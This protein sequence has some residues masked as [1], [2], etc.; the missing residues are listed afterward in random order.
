MRAA[1]GTVAKGVW[2]ALGF[3]RGIGQA[4]G[5]VCAE[6]LCPYPPG[7]PAIAP[8]EVLS[9]EVLAQLQSV[10]ALG[11]SVNGAGDDT[12]STVEVIVEEQL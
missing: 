9:E 4:I 12:L 7:I 11:G 8:G 1:L 6:L 10:L 5:R 3:R 2:F